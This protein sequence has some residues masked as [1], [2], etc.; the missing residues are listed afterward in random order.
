MN[1]RCQSTRKVYQ[2]QS[3]GTNNSNNRITNMDTD[4]RL[5]EKPKLTQY[6]GPMLSSSGTT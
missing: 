5:D 3:R 1:W 6:S 4:E 2:K